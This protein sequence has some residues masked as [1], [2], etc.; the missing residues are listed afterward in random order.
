MKKGKFIII[1]GGDGSGKSTV[2]KYVTQKL[3]DRG[4][5]I[6]A[7]REPGGSGVAEGIRG[8]FI[9]TR[10]KPVT[11]LFCFLA[12]RSA[13]V[14]QFLAPK[15]KSGKSVITDRSYPST[16]VYQGIAGGLGTDVVNNLNAMAM[17]KIKPDLI[18][19]LDVE[20]EEGLKRSRSTGETNALE[21]ESI[22]FHKQVNQSY[23]TLAHRYHWHI[24]D[25]MKPLAVVERGVYAII[26]A[27]MKAD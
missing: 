11:Q 25:A 9:N 26:S 12:A 16:I 17:Q 23:L 13:W 5:D 10:L 27:L 19:V 8:S 14:E 20:A 24:I 2:V 15:L 18:I 7:T 3:N 21:E 6:V 22:N 4:V 1:E